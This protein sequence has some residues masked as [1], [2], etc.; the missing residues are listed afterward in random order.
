MLTRTGHSRMTEFQRATLGAY[1]NDAA[2]ACYSLLS[3]CLAALLNNHTALHH[4]WDCL[5]GAHASKRIPG[6]RY[7]ITIASHRYGANVLRAAERLGGRDCSRLNRLHGRHAPGDHRDKLL[8]IIAVWI[9]TAVGAEDHLHTCSLGGAE[10]LAL[11]ATNHPLLVHG[12]LEHA[13]LLAFRED[14]VVIVDIHVEI[15]PV[16]LGQGESLVVGKTG[17]LDRI[18][19]GPDGILDA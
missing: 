11:L 9:Y 1:P 14:V 3:S 18:H 4:E 12:F 7:Q 16:L 2:R 6:H 19:P 13:I 17:V 15:S 8:R 10:R 5:Q